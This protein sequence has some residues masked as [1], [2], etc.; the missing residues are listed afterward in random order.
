[1]VH[2]QEVLDMKGA[3]SAARGCVV[4]PAYNEEMRIGHIVSEV[5]SKGLSCIV[6]DDGSVDKTKEE[7]EREG[8][9]VISHRKNHGK[10]LSLRD[11]FKKALEGDYVF[12][13]TMDGDGQHHPDELEH[14]VKAA[15]KGDAD[16]V[17]GNRMKDPKD[18]PLRRRITNRFMSSVISFLAGQNLPDTQCGYRLI[19]TKVLRAVPLTTDK[20]EIESEVLIEA[21]NA[22]FKI[23]S[24]PIKSIYRGQKSQIRPFRDTMRFLSF[25]FQTLVKR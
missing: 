11:G 2:V 4:I 19:S 22:G 14:F 23:K 7:A 21:A 20:Y 17:L 15:E 16:I 25:I 9:Q 12:I 1:M 8:A 5:V 10:G 24:I 18:M 13:I 6:I 3:L